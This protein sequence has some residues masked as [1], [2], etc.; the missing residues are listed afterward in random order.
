[1]KTLTATSNSKPKLAIFDVEGVLIPKNR[2]FYDIAKSMGF[3]P[4][5]KV[6]FYGFMYQ[7]GLLSLKKTLHRIFLL[8]KGVKVD[9]FVETLNK[10]PFMPDAKEVFSALHSQGCKTALI[11][12]GLPTFLV[13]QLGDLIG[14]DYAI[15]F[16]VGVKDQAVTGEAWGDVTEKNGKLLVLKELMEDEHVSPEQCIIVAD[17]RNNSSIFLKDAQKIGYDPDFVIRAKADFVISGRLTKILPIINGSRKV[18]ALPSK[19]E[20][21]R[22][23]IHGSGI[24]IPLL[25]LFFG[26]PA[27]SVFICSV[28]GFYSVSEFARVRGKSIPFFSAVTRNAASKSE[29]C[30]FTY[31]PIYFA[32]GILITLL[33]FRAPASGAAIAIFC[34][35]DSAASLIGGTV[36]K[37]ALP[38]NRAKTLEGSLGG[39]FFAFLAACIFI[40]PLLALIGAGV[41]MLVEYL[42]L[43]INDNLTIPIVTGL[44]LTLIMTIH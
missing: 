8:M 33:V 22:E 11:S 40:S 7:T 39:F 15:G 38:F 42:P 34:L 43:P 3:L 4:L 14:A 26:I 19:D 18:K 28:V 25:A 1:M 32:G 10:I 21:F 36:S 13:E 29:L 23:F 16:E 9:V 6:L 2:L 41:G 37:K 31:A 17:D 5:L 30:Q 12:S 20:F 27:I 24:F 35:G 44:A